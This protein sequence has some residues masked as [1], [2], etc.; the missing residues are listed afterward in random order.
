M[1]QK[2]SLPQTPII[3]MTRKTT[4]RK[5]PNQD[6]CLTNTHIPSPP[7]LPDPLKNPVTKL[8]ETPKY[9]NLNKNEHIQDTTGKVP[10]E[11]NL[12]PLNL[13]T[14]KEIPLVK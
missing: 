4:T 9:Q 3:P 12:S 11:N 10:P 7:N 2:N 8:K 13:T 6:I 1:P 5:K 14:S